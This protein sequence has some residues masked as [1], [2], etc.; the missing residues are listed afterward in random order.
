MS[1]IAKNPIL[2]GFYPDP[3]ICA[4]GE[5]F[6]LVNST[7]SYFPG[8]PI[9]HSKDL[10]NWEQIG[11][12]LDRVSQLPLVKSGH[13]AGLYAPTIRYNDGIFYLICTNVS[14]R[15]NFIVTAT[16]PRGPWSE[17]YYLEGADGIDPSLFFDEDGK[18]YYIGTHPNPD[19]VKYNGDWFIWI[20]EID[21]QKMELI[22]EKKNVWNGSMKNVI[23]PEGPHI[24]KMNGYYYI[25]HAE[26]GTGPD[27]CIAVTRSKS[28]WGPYENYPKNPIITHRHLGKAYPIQYVGHGDLVE[29]KNG[30]WYMVMLAVRPLMGYTTMGRETFLAKVTWEEDWPV[31]NAGVGI[32]TEE[33]N[34]D[35]DPWDPMKDVNSYTYQTNGKSAYPNGNKAYDFTKMKEIGD[36]FLLLRNPSDEMYKFADDGL[37][38]TFGKDLLKE[39]GNPSFLSIRQQHHK[40]I[41]SAHFKKM[42]LEDQEAMGLVLM[43][44]NEYHLCLEITK[45]KISTILCQAKSDQVLKEVMLSDVETINGDICLQMVIDGLTA[46]L[47]V[48]E[49]QEISL[50]ECSIANLSTEVAGGFVGC[51]IGVY[52]TST[53]SNVSDQSSNHR[54]VIT[55]F[56]YE[57]IH[58]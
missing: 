30:E 53:N 41:A 34:I 47:F 16:D 3:S 58:D 27:H 1:V 43:Q 15:D 29:T 20:Q 51:T 22:G 54:A 10:A 36:E 52:A 24:Y 50:S 57:S 28:V 17:P 25:L 44:S 9:L 55:K 45:D 5:D 23:W 40:F 39:E 37:E 42:E 13:S 33:V 18:C 11:N 2:P 7:F 19:G 32:L 38:L 31:V 8:L 46:K 48:G 6:Y 12:A 56:A 35:L 14:H 21:V 4:V 26:G 49:K